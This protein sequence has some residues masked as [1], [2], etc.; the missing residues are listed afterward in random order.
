M[1]TLM[2]KTKLSALA[3]SVAAFATITLLA[4]GS[5]SADERQAFPGHGTLR[6]HSG[7]G[8]VVGRT[9][10]A[11]LPRIRAAAA[12]S[13]R[14]GGPRF[15]RIRAAAASSAP[16]GGPRSPHSGGGSVVG[17]TGGATL[18]PH[19]GGGGVVG[20]TGGATLPRIRTAAPSSARPGGPCCRRLEGLER[21]CRRIRPYARSRPGAAVLPRAPLPVSG[22]DHHGDGDH[23]GHHDGYGYGYGYDHDRPEIIIEGAPAAVAVPVAVPAQVPVAAPQAVAQAPC[24]CL[25]KQKLA[26]GTVLFQDICT[27]ESSVL[28]PQTVGAR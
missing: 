14:P 12:S 7:G 6:P 24:N 17:T 16:P 25:T 19:S 11:T 23:D 2:T 26:D 1:T 15:P 28:A 4:N 20:T 27:K 10:G 9:G 5:A 22:G 21:P 13:A 18:P 8:T 3:L